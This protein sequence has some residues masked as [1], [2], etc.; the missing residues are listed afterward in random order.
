MLFTKDQTTRVGELTTLTKNE[1][2]CKV[3]RQVVE[4]GGTALRF[5]EPVRVQEGDPTPLSE[6]RRFYQRI[7]DARKFEWQYR[8][9]MA[10]RE[11]PKHQPW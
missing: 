4:V 5:L 7:D 11:L 3:F 1:Q 8:T 10:F 2:S 9:S 6:A